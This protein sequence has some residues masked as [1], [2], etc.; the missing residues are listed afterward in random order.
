[1]V[2]NCDGRRK[3]K[4]R[5]VQLA[6]FERPFLDLCSL[7]RERLLTGIS[8]GSIDEMSP[9]PNPA[10][11]QLVCGKISPD[12]DWL[13]TLPITSLHAKGY[14]WGTRKGS[15]FENIPGSCIQCLKVFD[16]FMNCWQLFAIE[17]YVR[18]A[19]QAKGGN[20]A[21]VL[22]QRAPESWLDHKTWAC[23]WEGMGQNSKKSLGSWISSFNKTYFGHP[24]ISLWG[25]YPFHF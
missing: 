16:P 4:P 23:Q 3:S 25:W 24:N 17:V 15:V 19:S 9:Q 13:S 10:W 8:Q 5:P 2:K 14:L 12:H 18:V 1:M 22:D 21:K 7:G 20:R 11:W 6:F